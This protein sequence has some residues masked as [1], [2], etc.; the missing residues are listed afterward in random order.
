MSKIVFYRFYQVNT[1][2]IANAVTKAIEAFF[3]YDIS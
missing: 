3:K 1:G 2:N